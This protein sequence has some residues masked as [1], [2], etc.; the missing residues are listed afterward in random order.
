VSR[1]ELE[2]EIEAPIERCYDLSLSVDAHLRSTD[3]TGE[4]V[5]DG[6]R[7]GVL[8]IGDHL[9]WEARHFGLWLRMSITISA[10]D[11]PHLRRLLLRRNATIRQLAEG[12]G[13]RQFVP[14]RSG[15]QG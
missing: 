11:P 1:I 4:R 6:V 10:A 9:T 3:H 15:N 8:T 14:D 7:S 2:T 13:W 12:D 5:V